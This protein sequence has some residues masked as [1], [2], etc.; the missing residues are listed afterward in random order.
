MPYVSPPGVLRGELLCEFQQGGDRYRVE[1][2]HHEIW[3]IEA[4]VFRNDRFCRGRRFYTREL[5]IQWA[6]R[7]R[8]H[9]LGEDDREK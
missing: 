5:A 1:L 3:G 4:Q 8:A 6:E 9:L 7:E 2:R